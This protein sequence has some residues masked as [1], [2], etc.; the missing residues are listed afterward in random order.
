MFISSKINMSHMIA[1]DRLDVQHVEAD[2]RER[3]FEMEYENY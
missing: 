2:A 1:E 3:E